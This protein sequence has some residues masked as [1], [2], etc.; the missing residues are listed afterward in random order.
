V[1]SARIGGSFRDIM[2]ALRVLGPTLGE[3]ALVDREL[4]SALWNL[5]ELTRL[6]ALEEDGM[7]REDGL[8]SEEELALLKRWHGM[9]CYAVMLLLEGGDDA[10]AFQEYDRYR[11]EEA[12]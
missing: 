3:T 6:W 12:S 5:C 4:V 10:E 1:V 7:L 8:L 2:G 11:L 9:L